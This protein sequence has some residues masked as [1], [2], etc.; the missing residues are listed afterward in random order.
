M[1]NGEAV[2][3]LEVVY[4]VVEMERF[5]RRVLVGVVKLNGEPERAVLLHRRPHKESAF[6]KKADD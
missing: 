4:V 1:C 3:R 6:K 5:L 2:G